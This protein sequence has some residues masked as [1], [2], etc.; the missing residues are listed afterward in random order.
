VG[1][2]GAGIGGGAIKRVR[3]WPALMPITRPRVAHIRGRSERVILPGVG[4]LSGFGE[5]PGEGFGCC[6]FVGG[7]GKSEVA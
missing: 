7:I 4:R 2:P 3:N 5:N 6:C 1:D